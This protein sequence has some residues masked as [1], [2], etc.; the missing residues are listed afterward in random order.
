M[1]GRL[2]SCDPVDSLTDYHTSAGLMKAPLPSFGPGNMIGSPEGDR[3][4]SSVQPSIA[5]G[6]ERAWPA[7]NAIMRDHDFEPCDSELRC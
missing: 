3:L 4:R 2:R 7:S 1:S 6:P 5:A